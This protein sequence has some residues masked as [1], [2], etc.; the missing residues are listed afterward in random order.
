MF[1]TMTITKAAGALFGSLLVF[2][3]GA[4]VAGAIYTTGGGHGD[5]HHQAYVIP[6]GEDD[7]E[8]AE[9]V[10]EVSFEELMASADA[11]KG[12]KL[13]K[14]CQ[15]CHKLEDGA[16]ATGP[17]LYQVVN[18]PVQAVDSFG[19]YSGVLIEAAD[20]WTPENLNAFLANP[21][22]FAPGNKMAFA[23]F[24]KPEERA[25]IIAFLENPE[26]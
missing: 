3:L 25:N 18:R 1:D 20:V 14:K 15:A 22:D 9:P 12:A 8:A 2:L 6:T 19:G 17:T 4:W 5:D 24:K 10:E 21:K 26:G 13:F 11:S 23:G 7:G 16:N